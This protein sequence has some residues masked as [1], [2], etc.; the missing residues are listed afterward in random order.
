MISSRRK[1]LII[2][3]QVKRF[4]RRGIFK[5]REVHSEYYKLY[6]SLRDSD[7]EF[8]YRYL[9]MSKE[10]FDHLL[11]LVR[12]KIT[13]KDTRLREAIT[14][15]ERLVITLRYLSAGMS[16]QDLCYNFR[17]GRATVSNILKEV[18]DAI[19]N[20]LSS[21]YMRAPSRENEWRHIVDDF[22]QLWDLPHCIGAIDRKHIGIDCPKKS[23]SNFYNYKSFFSIVLLAR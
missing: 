3:K 12:E 18:C 9:R 19:Y 4:W 8:Y 6:Q 15:E 10:R 20:V 13:E 17:V 1:Q 21:I 7:R 5:D 23:G 11:S 2:K 22:E 16:R 14:A